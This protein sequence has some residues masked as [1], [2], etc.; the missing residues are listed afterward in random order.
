LVGVPRVFNRIYDKVFMGVA[1]QNCLTKWYFNKAYEAQCALVRQGKP[2]D[3]TYDA[4]IFIPLRKKVGLE[5]VRVTLTGAAPC[6]PWLIEFLRVVTGAPVLQGYGMTENAACS[7][8]TLP[9]DFTVGH[10]GPPLCNIEIKLMDIPEMKYT[11]SSPDH[12]PC[13]EICVRG[14]NVFA[15]Y[16]K[17]EQA[18]AEC[19]TKD[20]WLLT[21]D[22]GR[23]NANGTLSIIDRKKNIFKLSQGEYIAS[24]KIESVYSQHSCSQQIWVYGNGFKSFVLAVVVPSGEYI[25]RVAVEKK[26]TVTEPPPLGSAPF[27]SWF[28]DLFKGDTKAEVKKHILDCLRE[29]EKELKGFEKVKDILIESKIDDN[30]MGFTEANECLT[31]TA[32]L[33]RPFLLQRYKAQ[34]QDLY[35]ANGEPGRPDE[36]WP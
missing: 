13:G 10:V 8:V 25:A 4:K 5:R 26:W 9:H 29:Q 19:L 12:P 3:P 16:Y 36:V 11:S 33:R 30:L 27:A 32:K 35:A 14:T 18:T 31:P 28:E 21:G 24:E 20:G 23:W 17:N 22:V 15:G 34:L 7:T 2:S 1:Q 6:P